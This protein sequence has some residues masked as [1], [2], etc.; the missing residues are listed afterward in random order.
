MVS[1]ELNLGRAG[2]YLALAD[3]LL[4][5]YQCFD[6]GQGV[7]YDLVMEDSEGKLLRVQVKTTAQKKE[8]NSDVYQKST[9]SYF[10]HIKRAGKN[11]ARHYKENDFDLYA[12]VMIDIKQVAYLA[13]KNI[14]SASITLRDKSLKYYNEKG[15]KYYQDLT[16]EKA[17]RE[18]N[19]V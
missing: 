12:L 19:V 1:R 11:G 15:A 8:W 13:N 2:E 6:S 3:I 4:K 5:G 14:P 17:I 7:G 9:E 18:I 10:F 16:L